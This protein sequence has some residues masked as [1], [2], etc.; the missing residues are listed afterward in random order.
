VTAAQRSWL[1][2]FSDEAVLSDL[3][4]ALRTMA[5]EL[6]DCDP[7]ECPHPE[8]RVHPHEVY[9]WL[10]R[11]VLMSQQRPMR[12]ER[13]HRPKGRNHEQLNLAIA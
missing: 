11:E 12:F 13:G 4:E 2:T 9:E 7:E 6:D 3:R 5:G 10:E 8:Q 1:A